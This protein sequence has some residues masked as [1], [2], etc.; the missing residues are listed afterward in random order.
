MVQL[1][2][3]FEECYYLLDDGNIYNNKSGKTIK[4]DKKHLFYLKT[5]EGRYKKIALKTIYKKLYN[6]VFCIDKIENI[7]D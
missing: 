1:N 3:G 5:N 2:N 4:P 6:K 7:K